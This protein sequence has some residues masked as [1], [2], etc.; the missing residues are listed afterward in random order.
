MTFSI[1]LSSTLS[2]APFQ[3]YLLFYNSGKYACFNELVGNI[4]LYF[5]KQTGQLK[6]IPKYFPDVLLYYDI[7]TSFFKEKVFMKCP[8]ATFQGE[9]F[10]ESSRILISS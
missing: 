6:T 3:S 9:N 5:S 10:H 7:T 8:N 4:Y 1:I 2:Q